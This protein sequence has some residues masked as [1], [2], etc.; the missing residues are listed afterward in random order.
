M[1]TAYVSQAGTRRVGIGVVLA[2]L[3]ALGTA[4]AIYSAPAAP[5]AA[6]PTALSVPAPQLFDTQ[7][8]G[9]WPGH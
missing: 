6:I 4:A 2:A 9:Y 1:S 8:E 3:A 5:S 7:V